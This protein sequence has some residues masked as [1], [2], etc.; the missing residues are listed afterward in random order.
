[1]A[2]SNVLPNAKFFRPIA[3]CTIPSMPM[4]SFTLPRTSCASNFAA[5]NLVNYTMPQNLPQVY[6][7]KSGRPTL[8]HT[9]NSARKE[10]VAER[11]F[12]QRMLELR[13]EL[14]NGLQE[15]ELGNSNMSRQS[16]KFWSFVSNSNIKSYVIE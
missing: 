7:L 11:S 5:K 15:M 12:F 6:I 4:L 1:M 8:Y 13:K 14:S 10:R 3:L 2:V 16:I 9:S